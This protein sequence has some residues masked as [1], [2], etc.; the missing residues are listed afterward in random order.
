MI[1]RLPDWLSIYEQSTMKPGSSIKTP[2][3][4]NREGGN[5]AVDQDVETGEE[6]SGLHDEVEDADGLS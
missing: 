4:T 2:V 6:V 5:S 1:K 3:K